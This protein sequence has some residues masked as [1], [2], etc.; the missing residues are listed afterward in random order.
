MSVQMARAARDARKT[1][2][3]KILDTRFPIL[4]SRY[5]VMEILQYF[6]FWPSLKGGLAQAKGGVVR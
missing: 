2:R 3:C 4:I 1:H 6:V 5:L